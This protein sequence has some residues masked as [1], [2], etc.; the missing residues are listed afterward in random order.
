MMDEIYEELFE[1]TI[2]NSL[3]DKKDIL[4]ED[5]EYYN[6]DIEAFI[7]PCAVNPPY[8]YNAENCPDYSEGEKK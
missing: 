6:G 1:E 4:C 5:C 2:D 7:L 8:M 3:E